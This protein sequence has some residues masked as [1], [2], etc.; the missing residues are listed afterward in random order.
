MNVKEQP[1]RRRT[2]GATRGRG[3]SSS[4]ATGYNN[5][6]GPNIRGSST[7]NRPTSN[8]RP[9]QDTDATG[10]CGS[11]NWSQANQGR[12]HPSASNR[13]E[14]PEPLSEGNDAQAG[15]SRD[16]T[17]MAVNILSVVNK[18]CISF[19]TKI[20]IPICGGIDSDCTEVTLHRV[21]N[22]RGKHLNSGIEQARRGIKLKINYDLY[23]FL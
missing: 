9:T 16:A 6:R 4:Y 11:M 20:K 19:C 22:F 13:R 15:H 8:E 2:Y 10:R 5:P 21:A 7:G 17:S 12:S 1:N 14:N 3:S 23:S 18:F